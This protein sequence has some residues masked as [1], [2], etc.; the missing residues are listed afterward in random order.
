MVSS[1]ELDLDY[2]I[3]QVQHEHAQHDHLEKNHAL[4]HP[5]AL[6]EVHTPRIKSKPHINKNV[7][8]AIDVTVI[9]MCWKQTLM[10]ISP[11]QYWAI[12]PEYLQMLRMTKRMSRF[13]IILVIFGVTEESPQETV[14]GRGIPSCEANT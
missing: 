2:G 1:Y 3:S 8:K 12:E 10:L 14:S 5:S 9:L 4:L 6:S 7:Y 13:Q 11:G